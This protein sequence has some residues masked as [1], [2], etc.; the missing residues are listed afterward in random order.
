MAQESVPGP[1]M[2][3]GYSAPRPLRVSP[4]QVLTLFLRAETNRPIPAAAARELPLPVTLNGYSAALRQTFSPAP[5]ALPLFAVYPVNDCYGLVPSAC[6]SLTAITVQIPWE[7][8]PNI[9]GTRRPENFAVLT[10]S[11]QGT[12]GE[13]IPLQADTDSIH[14]LNSCDSIKG[15]AGIEETAGLCRPLVV[16]RDGRIVTPANPAVGGETLTMYAYGLGVWDG[17]VGTGAAA[18]SPG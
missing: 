10:I 5:I 17:V 11:Y 18:R 12:A 2:S 9:P 13:A 1:V 6:T 3:A 7:L 8:T 14:V 4:G 15:V 16:H